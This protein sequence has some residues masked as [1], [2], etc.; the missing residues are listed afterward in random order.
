MNDRPT[1]KAARVV[2]LFIMSQEHPLDLT[3]I[4]DLAQMLGVSKITLVRDL[5]TLNAAKGLAA[6]IVNSTVKGAQ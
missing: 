2:A 4:S 5:E 6:Q 3:N 1:T